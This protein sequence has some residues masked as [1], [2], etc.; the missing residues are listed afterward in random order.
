MSF[1][2]AITYLKQDKISKASKYFCKDLYKKKNNFYKTSIDHDFLKDLLKLNQ[3]KKPLS[4]P[5]CLEFPQL[6]SILQRK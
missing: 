4:K 6:P 3:E 5:L 1:F 2:N